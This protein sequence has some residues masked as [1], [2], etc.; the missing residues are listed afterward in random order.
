M[1]CLLVDQFF[2]LYIPVVLNE[3]RQ[4]WLIF[5]KVINDML[6]VEFIELDEVFTTNAAIEYYSMT[7]HSVRQDNVMVFLS[8][9][10]F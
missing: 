6:W 2:Q 8:I 4:H 9:C 1:I 5:E 7:D 3:L 10:Y